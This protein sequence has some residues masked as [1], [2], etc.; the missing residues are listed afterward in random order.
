[1]D[2]GLGESAAVIQ[3]GI[4]CDPALQM[5]SGWI[6]DRGGCQPELSADGQV[7]SWFVWLS[8]LPWLSLDAQVLV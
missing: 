2:R 8:K 4:L 5:E 3:G 7:G 1:M 6:P